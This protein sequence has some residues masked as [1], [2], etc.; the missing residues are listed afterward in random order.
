MK[1]EAR[2]IM[3]KVNGE[4]GLAYPLYLKY[5]QDVMNAELDYAVRLFQKD[6]EPHC[7]QVEYDG[8]MIFVKSIE[9]FED[10]GEL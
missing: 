4:V 10:L 7:Y 5:S 2:I 6:D 8:G 9:G 1:L 3:D